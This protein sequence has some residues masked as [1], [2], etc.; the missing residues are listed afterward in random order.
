MNAQ[1]DSIPC[2]AHAADM[3]TETGNQL[4]SHPKEFLFSALPRFTTQAPFKQ[5][6]RM[7]ICLYIE[8]RRLI[9]PGNR[10]SQTSG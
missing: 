10:P 8:R 9:P 3:K 6:R 1:A 7:A 4:I 2:I 5:W